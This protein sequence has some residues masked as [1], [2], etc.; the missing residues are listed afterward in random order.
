MGAEDMRTLSYEPQH[1]R[2]RVAGVCRDDD[3]THLHEAVLAFASHGTSLIV[4]LTAV[5]EATDDVAR[6]LLAAQVASGTCRV[7]L[8]RKSDSSVDRR[9]RAAQPASSDRRR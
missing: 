8:V 4:D 9:L 7:T 3:A 5:T 2:L 1:P 6:A